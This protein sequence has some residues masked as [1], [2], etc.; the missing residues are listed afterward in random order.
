ML[1]H[2]NIF[3]LQSSSFSTLA[4]ASRNGNRSGS[5]CGSYHCRGGHRAISWCD[6]AADNENPMMGYAGEEGR[7]EEVDALR[8]PLVA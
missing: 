1:L 2:A 8:L 6:P 4:R 3:R 7:H 5:F